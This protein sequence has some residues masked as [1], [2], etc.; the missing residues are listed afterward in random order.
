[1]CGCKSLFHNYRVI[2][3][4]N[5]YAS[6]HRNF[7]ES[8]RFSYIK[9]GTDNKPWDGQP[10]FTVIFPTNNSIQSSEFS[11]ENISSINPDLLN[12]YSAEE[13]GW[14]KGS[15]RLSIYEC[16]FIY[17]SENQLLAFRTQIRNGKSQIK[18]GKAEGSDYY[19][20]PLTEKQ[21]HILFGTN[22]TVTVYDFR[23]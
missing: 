20:L 22:F 19:R 6:G 3:Q 11:V 1:M 8:I 17:S 14:P 21:M 4:D 16:S 13:E 2:E 15:K 12:E 7:M 5:I 23:L 18:L 9:L 10:H